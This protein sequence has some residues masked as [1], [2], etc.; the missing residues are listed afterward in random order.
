VRNSAG[1]RELLIRLESSPVNINGWIKT[2]R[3]DPDWM[4]WHCA[5][6]E[7]N[8]IITTNPIHQKQT[9]YKLQYPIIIARNYHQSIH[10]KMH[11]KIGA[12][13]IIIDKLITSFHSKIADR[14]E[15][16]DTL[17]MESR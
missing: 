10:R 2:T 15:Q 17:A 14:N 13:Q 9:K 8:M 4:V 11:T 1:H 3:H 16:I 12:F 5:L 6:R 7:I